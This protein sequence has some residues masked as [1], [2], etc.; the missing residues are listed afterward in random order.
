MHWLTFAFALELAAA[1]MEGDYWEGWMPET[2]LEATAVAFDLLEV[3]GASSVFMNLPD[4]PAP[5]NWSPR[6]ADFLFWASVHWDRFE[7]G[8]EHYCAHAFSSEVYAV[9][10]PWGA[11]VLLRPADP[12]AGGDRVYLRVE[13]GRQ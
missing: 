7:L 10:T 11:P 6:F 8:Y 12:L 3:G 4:N 2:R 1:G 13:L 5:G 9:S